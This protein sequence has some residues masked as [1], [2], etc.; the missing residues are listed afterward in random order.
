MKKYKSNS[1]FILLFITAIAPLIFSCSAINKK[2]GTT[3]SKQKQTINTE[4]AEELKRMHRVDQEVFSPGRFTSRK[5]I[6]E[7]MKTKD[8]VTTTHQKRAAEILDQHGYPGYDLVGVEAS[9]SYW[10]IVQHADHAPDFQAEVLDKMKEEVAKSN[11]TSSK[12][13]LLFDRVQRNNDKPQRYGTQV[14]YNKETC[15]AIPQELEDREK[16]SKLRAEVGLPPLT[17]YLNRMTLNFYNNNRK[18]CEE[19]GIME[20]PLNE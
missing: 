16:V 3:D 18:K 2:N 9:D 17:E 19:K 5:Q 13:A 1:T 6:Q 7:W 15:R 11:A 12:M 4:L 8:S 10:I 14:T 20:P